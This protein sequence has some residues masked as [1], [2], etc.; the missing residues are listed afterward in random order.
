MKHKKRKIKYKRVLLLILIIVMIMLSISLLINNNSKYLIIKLNGEKE[1]TIN[2]QEEYQDSGATATYKNKDITSDIETSNNINYNKIG[3]YEIVYKIKYKKQAKEIT[4]K[5]NI[6]DKE[7]PVIELNGNSEI[8]IYKGSKYNEQ[9]VK[10]TDNYDEN[11]TD[12]VEIENNIDTS[13]IGDYEITYKVKDSSGNEAITKRK[14]KVI[15]KLDKIDSKTNV[16]IGTS[17]KGY[18]IEIKNG[19]T[20]VDGILIANKTY[21]LPSDYNPGGLLQIFTDNFNKMKND[22]KK[23]QVSLVIGSGFRSYNSQ[24]NIYNNYVNRDGKANADTYSARPGHSE[25]QTGLAADIYGT[26]SKN[27]YLHQSWGETKD[28]KWLNDNCYKYGFVIRYVKGKEDITGYMYESWHI[29]YVGKELAEKLYNNGNWIT[30][31]E[32]FGITSK[33]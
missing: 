14:I 5:I 30:L 18:I 29:R 23:D 3:N 31:E 6:V 9:G 28:G 4:R 20:Y 16:I 32:Y 7:N 24:K 26:D 21:A 8:T 22:A 25:H 11:L 19:I 2:Y 15:E 13:K 33:Y 10:I 12:K 1:I 27:L 17:S